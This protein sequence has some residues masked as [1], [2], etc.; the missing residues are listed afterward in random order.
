MTRRRKFHYEA[1]TCY[2]CGHKTRHRVYR[3]RRTKKGGI[4]TRDVSGVINSLDIGRGPFYY[5]SD[6]QLNELKV[7]NGEFAGFATRGPK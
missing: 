3:P 7:K 2:E 1:E 5:D 6:G 4:V